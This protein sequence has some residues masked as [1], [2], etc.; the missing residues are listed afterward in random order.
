M[1]PG[2]NNC[3]KNI[4]VAYLLHPF[5]QYHRFATE[6]LKPWAFEEHVQ[7]LPIHICRRRFVIGIGSCNHGSRGVLQHALLKLQIERNLEYNLLGV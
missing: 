4:P 5:L 3:F 1:R 6:P 2:S 7:A